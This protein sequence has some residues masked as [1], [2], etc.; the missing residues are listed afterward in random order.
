M[1]RELTNM[2]NGCHKHV[3]LSNTDDAGLPY[4]NRAA[5]IS[6]GNWYYA[7]ALESMG[8]KLCF[9]YCLV[10]IGPSYT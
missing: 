10:N 9:R 1:L 7:S 4:F 5:V 2:H 3:P 6:N 8:A